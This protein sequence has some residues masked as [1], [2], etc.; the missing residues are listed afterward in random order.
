MPT[1]ACG[2][3]I[4]TEGH[5]QPS[6]CGLGAQPDAQT[7]AQSAYIG[8]TVLI[9]S[10]KARCG[11]ARLLHACAQGRSA[12]PQ[13]RNANQQ[14]AALACGLLVRR[15]GM[16]ATWERT[17]CRGDRS[18]PAGLA[19]RAACLASCHEHLWCYRKPQCGK[20][21]KLK[22]AAQSFVARAPAQVLRQA[23]TH[24]SARA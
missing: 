7:A 15:R 4:L 17:H 9:A 5:A 13:T 11:G 18:P 12:W 6:V 3:T 16:A 23:H 19:P 21:F 24:T 1:G 14:A 2:R 10:K 22:V 20:M 8:V